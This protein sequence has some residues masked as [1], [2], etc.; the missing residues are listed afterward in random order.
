VIFLYAGAKLLGLTGFGLFAMACH[1]Y[2]MHAIA[3]KF[4]YL[5][6]P[7][8]FDNPARSLQ[9]ISLNEPMHIQSWQLNWALCLCF[10]GQPPQW[11]FVDEVDAGT[12]AALSRLVKVAH[13]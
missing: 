8:E 12:F 2:L 4:L 6:L 3:D 10:Q 7:G 11:V 9:Q 5:H 13:G 1:S